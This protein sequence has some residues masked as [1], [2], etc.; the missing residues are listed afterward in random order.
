MA[1]YKVI[2]EFVLNGIVQKENEIIELSYVQE[3][4]K[5]IKE[6][7][8]KVTVENTPSVS[9]DSSTLGS[10]KPGQEI[11][12]EQKEKLAKENAAESAN[13]Y[14]MAAEQ[15]TVDIAEGRGE[16]AVATV[17][18]LLKDKLE[19]NEFN[20]P[21]TVPNEADVPNVPDVPEV[22]NIPTV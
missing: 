16:P 14:A 21:E 8:E 9:S 2:K 10:L 20:K 18:N 17:A 3:N 11:T 13:A 15:R 1:K 12:P 4:L 5:S 22:P 6:N 7:I 19:N